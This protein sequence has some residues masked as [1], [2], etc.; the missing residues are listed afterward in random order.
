MPVL[1]N[2]VVSDL[3]CLPYAKARHHFIDLADTALDNLPGQI[4][5]FTHPE[6]G[7]MGEKL[8]SDWVWLGERKAPSVLVLISATH[9]VEGAMGSGLQREILPELI[10]LLL[11]RG[12]LA[13]LLIHALNPWGYAWSRRTD[14]QNI[15]LN[16]N[17]IDFGQP[18][19]YNHEYSLIESD[20]LAHTADRDSVIEIWKKELG[21]ER[22]EKALSSG[23]YHSS[24]GL[25]YGGRKMAWSHN[26][27]I[28]GLS[29]LSLT[30]AKRIIALDL[31]SGLGPYGY[32]EVISDHPI[33]SKG[34]LLSREWFGHQV[35]HT[36]R[37]N[38]C[39]VGKSGLLDYYFH[40]L[41]G[42]RG[43]FLTFEAGS[44]G[45]NAMFNLLCEDQILWN[46]TDL[47]AN[48]EQRQHA[49]LEHFCPADTH[50]QN[51]VYCRYRQLVNTAV[52]RLLEKP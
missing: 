26:T 40:D 33:N 3:F 13:V 38:S 36:A 16:R 2:P 6:L 29:T 9:G 46:R 12:Q 18:L 10:K 25:F 43:C 37:G 7:P 24:A 17:F 11:Q 27:L 22:F 45:N 8:T 50:W 48:E 49:M 47:Y 34:D 35:C 1:K 51:A 32:G 15:D 20:L 31:H 28:S 52:E 5:H 41:I 19:P 23:Q 14:H 30:Y 39:S 21:S 4:L 42:E 44:Y